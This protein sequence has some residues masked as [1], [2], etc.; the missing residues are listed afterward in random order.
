[1]AEKCTVLKECPKCGEI[2]VSSITKIH[3]D[4]EVEMQI[5]CPKCKY[6]EKYNCMINI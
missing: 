2:M 3:N 4:K 5:Y 1:M 6:S